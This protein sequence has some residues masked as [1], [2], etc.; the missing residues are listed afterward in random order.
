M[1]K[2]ILSKAHSLFNFPEK[3]ITCEVY[4]HLK[5]YVLIYTSVITYKNFNFGSTKID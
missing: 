3:F 4:V 5:C 1:R 2:I